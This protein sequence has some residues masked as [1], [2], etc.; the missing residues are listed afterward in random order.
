[1]F[2][3]EILDAKILDMSILEKLGMYEEGTGDD[4]VIYIARC[5]TVVGDVPL[6]APVVWVYGA[7]RSSVKASLSYAFVD[8]DFKRMPYDAWVRVRD[9]YARQEGYYALEAPP[10]AEIAAGM[11]IS[12]VPPDA[13]QGGAGE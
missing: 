12:D 10:G 1:M 9:S 2:Q 11:L 6:T 7:G 5:R 13:G 8:Y 3:L 4:V